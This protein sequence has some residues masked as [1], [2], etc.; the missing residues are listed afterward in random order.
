M[1]VSSKGSG[2]SKF[3]LRSFNYNHT[4]CMRAAKALVS[5]NFDLSLHLHPYFV[6]AS[7]KDSGEFAH[8]RGL[9]RVFATR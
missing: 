6:Y 4:L 1:F 9:I 8:M 3:W 2:E 7:N 5:L